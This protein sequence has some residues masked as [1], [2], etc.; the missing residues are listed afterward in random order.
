MAFSLEKVVP[1]G[2]CLD[3]YIGMFNLTPDDFKLNIL[4]CASGPASFNAEMTRQG[5]QVISCDPVYQFTAK[6]ISQRIEETYPIIIQQLE[7]NLDDYIWQRIKSP[8][9]LGRLRIA[10][11]QQFLLDFAGGRQQGRYVVGELPALPFVS[12]QFDLALCGHFLFSYSQQLALDFH[13][14]AILELCRVASEVRIFP[15]LNLS[16]QTSPHLLPVMTELKNQGYQVEIELGSYEFQ[17]GGNQ[18]LRVLNL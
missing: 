14:Q 9:D 12:K 16:G 11:M 18:F 3:E 2:R 5:Y 7:N 13:L 17:K 4:D 15:I 6:Q 10:A 8:T 1:W